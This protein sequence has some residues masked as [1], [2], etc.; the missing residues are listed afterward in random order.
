MQIYFLGDAIKRRRLELGL[1]QEQLC[2]GI[3]E[4]I[5]ISRLE[6]GKQTPSRARLE[7]LM[8]RLDMP[9]YQYYAL[10]SKRELEIEALQREIVSLNVKF[11]QATG[12]EKAKL[13]Q[14]ALQAHKALAEMADPDDKIS[15]QVIL[16]SKVILGKEDGRYSREEE[17]QML[18]QAIRLTC[19]SFDPE[20]IS[21]G[22]Y[23][24]REIK[25][26]NQ[27]ALVHVYAG[28]HMEAIEIYSQLYKYIRKHYRLIPPTTAHFPMI[29]F[30]Y[31]RELGLIGQYE[32]SIEIAQ[33]GR[34]VCLD[35]GHYLYLSSLLSIFAECYYRL[36]DIEKSKDY[37]YQTYYMTKA[38]GDTYNAEI[39]RNEAKSYLGIDLD[40]Q[41]P[42]P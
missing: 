41:N 17:R 27:L 10:L 8:E 22:L 16:R 6:N 21:R 30:N 12:E 11:G 2:E 34:Q 5:T 37:Y 20:D 28:E 29:A 26:I 25:I 15:Q 19:P 1:T 35:Y 38:I 39:T 32:K 42:H 33:E 3:C 24:S 7:A 23:T 31:A 36:G 9:Q 4:P 14:E 40:C 13:R 18:L